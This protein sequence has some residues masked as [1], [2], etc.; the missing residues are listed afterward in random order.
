MK[1]FVFMLMLWSPLQ[2]LNAKEALSVSEFFN[3]ARH[4][5][6]EQLCQE[7][8]HQDIHF[9]DPLGEVRGI[10]NLINY[11][12]NLYENLISISFEDKGLFKKDNEQV[13][14][15]KMSVQHK[16]IG[17]GDP[18]ELEGVS[19]IRYS[20]GKVIYHRDYFDLGAMIYEKLPVLGSMIRWIRE[21]AHGAN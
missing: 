11:Y 15:W 10:K 8:Y 18:I 9:I 5:N 21:K 17:G 12:K 6:I 14:L 3:L 20:D 7:F 1:L 2:K 13:Y 19:I 4:S 16:K